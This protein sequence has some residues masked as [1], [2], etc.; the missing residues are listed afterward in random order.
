M[1]YVYVIKSI[2]KD[3]LYVGS[4]DDLKRRFNQHNKKQNISTKFYAP[5]RL[6]YY[7]A[8]QSKVDALNRERMLK[9]KG[10]TIGHLKRRIINSINE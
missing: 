2:E 10:A 4:T 6:V 1:Y 9:H 7:E 8:Y 3:F 5:F